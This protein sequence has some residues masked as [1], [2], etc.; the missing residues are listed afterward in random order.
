[1]VSIYFAH[2]AAGVSGGLIGWGLGLP[3][4]FALPGGVVSGVI[5][6]FDACPLGTMA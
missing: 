5:G 1:M 6:G 4:A 2:V 3:P